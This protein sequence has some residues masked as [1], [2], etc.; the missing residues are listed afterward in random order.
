MNHL[1]KAIL[2][3]KKPPDLRYAYRRI[4]QLERDL[5]DP[6]LWKRVLK[7]YATKA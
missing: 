4:K 7:Y 1:A 2:Q 5:K 6:T 3:A